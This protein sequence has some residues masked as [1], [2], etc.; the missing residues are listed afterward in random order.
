MMW[1]SGHRES[2]RPPAL[3]QA[4]ASARGLTLSGSTLRRDGVVY[5][6]AEEM[7]WQGRR[8]HLGFDP[9]RNRYRWFRE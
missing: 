5:W 2:A 8:V 4:E 3:I 9:G 7:D 6:L 1:T